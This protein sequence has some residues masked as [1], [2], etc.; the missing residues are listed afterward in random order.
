LEGLEDLAGRG[1]GV[2]EEHLEA[3][4]AEDLL[5]QLARVTVVFDDQYAQLAIGHGRRLPR[6]PYLPR[7]PGVQHNRFRGTGCLT[8]SAQAV[9]LSPQ[10][11][12]PRTSPPPFPARAACASSA[13]SRIRRRTSRRRWTGSW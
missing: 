10:S 4:G 2:G 6:F 13:G 5:G 1:D 8:R 9:S 3:L 11:C 12:A 7:G